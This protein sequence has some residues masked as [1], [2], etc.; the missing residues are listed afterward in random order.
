MGFTPPLIKK[1]LNIYQR[2]YLKRIM[3]ALLYKKTRQVPSPEA[4][5]IQDAEICASGLQEEASITI[6]LI[7]EL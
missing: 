4:L 6:I 7:T 5:R 2:G 3:K 1:R